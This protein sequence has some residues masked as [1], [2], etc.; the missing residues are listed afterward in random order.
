MSVAKKAVDSTLRK[1]LNYTAEIIF[2][3]ILLVI[4]CLPL[5]FVV[6]MWIQHIVLGAPRTSLLLDPVIF[7]GL[8]G[9]FWITLLL[10]LVSFSIGYL[11]ISRSKPG[12]EID[13]DEAYED[14][15][16]DEEL[17]LEEDEEDIE[18]ELDKE[19]LTD[20]LEEEEIEEE[21]EEIEEEE[22]EEETPEE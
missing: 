10:G 17:D 13:E 12:S 7:F 6:P 5:A 16:D 18:D 4:I 22:E 19:E 9:A 1:I 21:E 2:S 3:I 8:D 11:F 20:A 15:I 14:E